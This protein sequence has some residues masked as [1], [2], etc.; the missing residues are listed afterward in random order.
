MLVE[1]EIE[2]IGFDCY[3]QFLTGSILIRSKKYGNYIMNV[4]LSI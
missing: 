1:D 2:I 4:G 3:N